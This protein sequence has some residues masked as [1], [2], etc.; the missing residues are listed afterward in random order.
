MQSISFRR[1]GTLHG[2]R[3]RFLVDFEINFSRTCV[4]STHIYTGRKYQKLQCQRLD[5]GYEC[6]EGSWYRCICSVRS[7]Q[8]SSDHLL[9]RCNRNIANGDSMNDA[10]IIRAVGSAEQVGFKVFFSFDYA[11]GSGTWDKQLVISI[12]N[13]WKGYNSYYK[14]G[15]QPLVSTFEGPNAAIDWKDIKAATGCFFV[16]DYSSLVRYF[17]VPCLSMFSRGRSQ[18]LNLDAIA[19]DDANLAFVPR[20]L[21]T[22]YI[23]YPEFQMVSSVGTLGQLAQLTRTLITML[24]ICRRLLQQAKRLT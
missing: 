14:R 10:Q 4:H 6:C 1:V 19:D 8:S 24:P 13:K 7:T 21:T 9:T 3:L 16:P 15:S 11:G 12:I 20:V 17:S 23:L 5:C 2:K 18:V 22:L